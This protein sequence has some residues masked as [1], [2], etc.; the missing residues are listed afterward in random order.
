MGERLQYA[1]PDYT[2]SECEGLRVRECVQVARGSWFPQPQLT[3]GTKRGEEVLMRVVSESYNILLMGLWRERGER[4]GE[5]EGEG[6]LGTW[7]LSAI[8]TD[9]VGTWRRGLWPTVRY[10]S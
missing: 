8:L 9:W 6:Y 1:T 7:R 2:V 10:Y 3:V 4:K 5:R